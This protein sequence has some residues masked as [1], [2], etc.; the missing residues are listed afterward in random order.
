MLRRHGLP[1]PAWLWSVPA[2]VKCQ[3]A[4]A[5]L[6][7]KFGDKLLQDMNSNSIQLPMMKKAAK[8]NILDE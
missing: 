5:V 8:K 6:P 2:Y 7:G 4:I 1:T 3:Q